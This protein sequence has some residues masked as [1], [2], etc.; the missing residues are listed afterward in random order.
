MKMI[1][2][3]VAY[4]VSRCS[5]RMC[6]WPTVNDAEIEELTSIN[7]IFLWNIIGYKTASSLEKNS[8][9]KSV[10]YSKT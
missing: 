6:I 2:K 8:Q 3:M 4:V 10:P 9:S 5:K 7:A 1:I